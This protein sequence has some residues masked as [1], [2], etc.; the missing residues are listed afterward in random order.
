M[1]PYPHWETLLARIEA[2]LKARKSG[3]DENLLDNSAWETLEEILLYQ[4]RVV[5]PH[6][7]LEYEDIEDIVHGVLLKLQSIE[8]IRRLQATRSPE[9]YTFVMLRNAANDLAR[10]RQLE[11]RLFSPIE[12][13]GPSDEALSSPEFVRAIEESSIAK[14][15]LQ[16]LTEEEMSLIRMRFGEDMSI[17]EIAA[18]MKMSYSATAVRLF[19]ILHRLRKSME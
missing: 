6:A 17:A 3:A 1:T 15:V 10:K 11:R 14:T 9:G 16:H 18:A 5:V 8:V 13:L 2:D 7:G 12:D 4:G 19:R